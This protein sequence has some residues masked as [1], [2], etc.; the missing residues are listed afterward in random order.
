MHLTINST[1]D[2]YKDIIV[3]QSAGKL[4]QPAVTLHGQSQAASSSFLLRVHIYI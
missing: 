1:Y 4:Q 2:I 3:G